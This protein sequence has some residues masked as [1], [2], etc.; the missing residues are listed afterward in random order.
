MC[1]LTKRIWYVDTTTLV[2]EST[3]SLF[4][5]CKL[6]YALFI[7]Y[8]KTAECVCLPCLFV[9]PRLDVVLSNKPSNPHSWE[10][11]PED[12]KLLRTERDGSC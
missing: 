5:R 8:S 2:F 4:A 3:A 6:L 10:L 1:W 12:F 11:R 7:A 9:S